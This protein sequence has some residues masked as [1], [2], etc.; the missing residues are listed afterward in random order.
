MTIS[1]EITKLNTNL[2]DSYTAV[3]NKGGTL[4]NSENFDNLPTAINSI[5]ELKGETR[6][7]ELTSYQGNTFTPTSGKN[8]ITSITVTP[9]NRAITLTPST[10]QQ[11]KGLAS[12]YLDG[13]S[14]YGKIT[15]NPVT[16]SIDPNI[17]ASNIKKDVVILGITGTYEGSGGVGLPREVTPSGY[18]Q[19]PSKNFSFVLPSN[20]TDLGGYV[21]NSAFRSCYYVTSVDMSSLT[22]ITGSYSMQNAF[23]SCN[24][25]TSV[26]LS[27][28]TTISGI[29]ALSYAF[30][31]CSN[32]T[33]VDLGS[34]TTGYG[35]DYTFQYCTKLTS[36]DMSSFNTE[37]VVS[38]SFLFDR[39][40]EL[41]SV[42]LGNFKTKN[43]EFMINIFNRC[44][45]LKYID[46]SNFSNEACSSS[47]ANF[48]SYLP[49]NGDIKVKKSFYE[50]IKKYIP[51][52][53]NVIFS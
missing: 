32:L 31:Y 29:S 12:S 6:T 23:S 43:V 49:E 16:S 36:V 7:E 47:F 24:N 3:S 46:I 22:S 28:L 21:L 50:N 27:N 51:E 53:W 37:K 26:D 19:M 8:G 38:M 4:P 5:T 9:K 11:E 30:Y 35:L 2:T 41:N 18:Y 15:V 48:S 40:S 33:S 52:K 34:L 13:Y 1:D 44:E 42:K 10:S 39:C 14:G 17:V 45:K 20:A 25:L